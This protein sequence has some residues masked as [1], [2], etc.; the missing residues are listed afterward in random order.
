MAILLGQHRHRDL[1]GEFLHHARHPMV[2]EWISNSHAERKSF[3]EIRKCMKLR[4][5]KIF[6]NGMG[7]SEPIQKRDETIQP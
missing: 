4:M 2:H 1:H 5:G 7:A 3:I 6:G